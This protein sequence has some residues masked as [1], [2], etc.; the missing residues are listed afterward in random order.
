MRIGI[1]GHFGGKENFTDGQTVKVKSLCNALRK[2]CKDLNIDVVDTYY[3]R[4]NRLKLFVSFLRML[5]LD[6]I[7]IFLPAFGGRKILFQVFYYL[8]KYC[9]KSVYHDCIAGSLDKELQ[10]HPKWIKYLNQFEENWMESPQQ[11]ERLKK[12]GIKNVAYIAN[13]KDLQH[14]S[15]EE[16]QSIKHVPPYRFCIF[17]RVEPMKGIEDA[18]IAIQKAN[19]KRESY[20]ILD[21]YGPIQHG[22]EDWFNEMKIKYA[23]LFN[24]KG[25]CHPNQSVQVLKDYFALIFSTRYFT[26]G[27][28]GTIIDAMFSGLPVIA[29]KW[30]WCD[31]MVKNDYNG[32]VYDFEKP[33]LLNDI[34][35]N[36]CNN[37]EIILRMKE[38]C[39]LESDRYSEKNVIVY[40]L[41]KLKL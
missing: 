8:S 9:G 24:Y 36:V 28:P 16:M 14:V 19:E 37:P 13:F 3:M 39:I 21:I 27:M 25:V 41:N 18:L 30:A 4:H 12:M 33:E 22:Y 32:I 26:E 40:I 10:E 35:I 5:F 20:A 6:K 31:N 23:G 29:R 38:N 11:V 34:I 1:L 7:I 17:S 15:C 2:Y